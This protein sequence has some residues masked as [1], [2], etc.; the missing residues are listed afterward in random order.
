MLETHQ[1]GL[2][3]DHVLVV[4]SPRY[5]EIGHVLPMAV[6]AREGRI[7]GD[8]VWAANHLPSQ[9]HSLDILSRPRPTH[10]AHRWLLPGILSHLFGRQLPR[11]LGRVAGPANSQNFDG[12]AF[13]PMDG[14]NPLR[15]KSVIMCLQKESRARPE[16][17]M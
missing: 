9:L 13:A 15:P 2:C 17:V 5:R 6:S 10:L 3:L 12:I 11:S 7:V 4:P 16:L 1:P 14:A 8:A